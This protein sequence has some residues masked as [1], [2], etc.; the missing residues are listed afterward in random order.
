MFGVLLARTVRS[1]GPT[2][3]QK[4]LAVASLFAVTLL[5]IVVTASVAI[6]RG[7]PVGSSSPTILP[8]LGI[9]LGGRG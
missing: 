6:Q 4:L 2:A 8:V 7:L 1:D 5:S 9:A 3:T